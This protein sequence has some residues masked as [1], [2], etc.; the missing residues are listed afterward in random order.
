MSLVVSALGSA[1]GTFLMRQ[2]FMQM[3]RELGEAARIDGA[4]HFQVFFSVYAKMAGPAIATLAILNFSGF[5]AEFYRPLIFLQTQDNFTL[6][7]GLVASAGKPGY[8]IHL[9]GARRRGAGHA[10]QRD[11]VHLRPAVLHRRRHGRV[12]AVSD[13][14][15][16]TP[17]GAVSTTA[18]AITCGRLG[19]TSTIPNGPIVLGDVAHLYFQSRPTADLSVPVEWGHLTSTDFVT[20]RLHRPAMAPV[21]DGLDRDG[22]YS[23][24]TV[25]DDGRVAGVLLGLRKRL[26]VPVGAHRGVRRRGLQLR[27]AD[28]GRAR[29]GS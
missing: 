28:P 26:A 9:G 18:P 10:A 23:G 4:G 7:L 5:W 13:S 19:A 11:L 27:P 20:W 15:G 1:F 25:L 2:Y 29:P 14:S 6:P 21:P 17:G 24:N 22:C 8:R 16:R 3:P 12:V